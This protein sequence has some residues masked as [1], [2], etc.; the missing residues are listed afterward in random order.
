MK[1]YRRTKHIF[2]GLR[3]YAR[4]A[5]HVGIPNTYTSTKNA[6]AY[7]DSYLNFNKTE[8]YTRAL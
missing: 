8:A 4:K 6:R 7:R 2:V 3:H 5:S 1:N